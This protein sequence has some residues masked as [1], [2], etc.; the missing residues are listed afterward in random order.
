MN[1]LLWSSKDEILNLYDGQ[2]LD[3]SK[4]KARRKAYVFIAKNS[5]L[6]IFEGAAAENFVASFIVKQLENEIKGVVAN[7]GNIKGTVKVLKYGVATFDKVS[8]LIKKMNKGDIL[9][10]E[11]TSPE[12]ITACKKASAIL[13]NQGGLLSHAAIISREMGIP[14]IVGLENITEL[15]GDGDQIEVN[16]DNGTVNILESKETKKGASKTIYLSKTFTRDHILMYGLLWHDSDFR[17]IAELWGRTIKNFVII[18]TPGRHLLESWYDVAE[19]DWLYDWV[20]RQCNEN[21]RYWPLVKK[22][23]YTGLK[24]ILPYLQNKKQLQ[25]INDFKKYY[26]ACLKW[27]SPAESMLFIPDFKVPADVKSEA[28]EIRTKTQHLT[29]AVD[30]PITRFFKKKLPEYQ[31]LARFIMPDEVVKLAHGK[32]SAFEIEDIRARQNGCALFRG[33]VIL[34]KD[35]P[36]ELAKAGLKFEEEEKIEATQ[37]KGTCVFPGRV[38]GTVKV[39]L[40]HDHIAKLKKGEILVSDMTTPVFVPAIR[41]AGAIVTNEGG[42]TCHAAIIAREMKKPCVVGTQIATRVLHDGDIVE[43]NADKGIITIIKHNN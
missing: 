42:S 31:D 20:A 6:L 18:M 11:T 29:E 24:P 26:S 34:F 30:Q 9:V 15:V 33:K 23:F 36:K 16:G 22:R 38:R 10:A 13:T 4:F 25:T 32:L 12:I 43:V 8:Q 17:H 19:L 21:P 40:R 39:I 27:Q 28:I 35:L 3:H 1:D 14:C 5:E 2:A 7:P 41:K 37:L